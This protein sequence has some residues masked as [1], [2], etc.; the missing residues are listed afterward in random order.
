MCLAVVAKV[1]SVDGQSAWCR[2]DQA[3]I[4]A[5]LAL[6]DVVPEPGDY[7]MI[8]AGFAIRRL[9]VEAAMESLAL[10]KEILAADKK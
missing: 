1:E 5:D 4:Q 10:M 8:H 9:D 2:L 6:L 7:L 3:L